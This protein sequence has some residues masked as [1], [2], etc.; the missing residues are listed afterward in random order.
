M[1]IACGSEEFELPLSLYASEW[2]PSAVS[3]VELAEPGG[4]PSLSPA[5]QSAWCGAAPFR[6]GRSRKSRREFAPRAPVQGR[7]WL[8]QAK[9]ISIGGSSCPN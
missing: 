5:H 2:L 7:R 9:F 6:L 1:R 3:Q 4:V 8:R